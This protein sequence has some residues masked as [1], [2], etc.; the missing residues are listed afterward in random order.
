[1]IARNCTRKP[2]VF[3]TVASLLAV[4]SAITGLQAWTYSVI[5]Q[6]PPQKQNWEVL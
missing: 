5:D 1:M 4:G 2:V 6:K 3:D